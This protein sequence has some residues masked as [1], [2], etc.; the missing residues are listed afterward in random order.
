MD[1]AL[2]LFDAADPKRQGSGLRVRVSRGQP[3]YV[4][5]LERRTRRGEGAG[6]SREEG[7]RAADAAGRHPHGRREL[8]MIAPA[9]LVLV[10]LVVATLAPCPLDAQARQSLAGTWTLDAP[11]GG[12]G[13]GRG[14]FAGFSTATRMVV[15][16]SP[17]EVTIETNTG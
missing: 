5:P 16:E 13:G 14:N 9:K 11:A 1:E 17:T 4:E 2:D 6:R 7:H 15:K 8:M 3:G 10:A 12:R